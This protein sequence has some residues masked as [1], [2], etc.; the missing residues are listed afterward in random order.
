MIR[1]ELIGT[2][3]VADIWNLRSLSEIVNKSDY[4]YVNSESSSVGGHILHNNGELPDEYEYYDVT[5]SDGMRG[6]AFVS[7]MHSS[8]NQRRC[9]TGVQFLMTLSSRSYI[10]KN[11]QYHLFSHDEKLYFVALFPD[12]TNDLQSV[13]EKKDA[14]VLKL[15]HIIEL[16]EVLSSL[17]LKGVSAGEYFIKSVFFNDR[18]NLVWLGWFLLDLCDERLNKKEAFAINRSVLEI[19]NILE[20]KGIGISWGVEDFATMKA[21]MQLLIERGDP[22]TLLCD[23]RYRVLYNMLEGV[24]VINN[25]P[26]IRWHTGLY[27]SDFLLSLMTTN[28]HFSLNNTKSTANRRASLSAEERRAIDNIIYYLI[29]YDYLGMSNNLSGMEEKFV[30]EFLHKCVDVYADDANGIYYRLFREIA[31][32]ISKRLIALADVFHYP[33]FSKDLINEGFCID[34]GVYSREGVDVRAVIVLNPELSTDFVRSMFFGTEYFGLEVYNIQD[35]VLRSVYGNDVKLTAKSEIIFVGNWEVSGSLAGAMS[36][37]V[38]EADLHLLFSGYTN[39]ELFDI[40][41]SHFKVDHI[42]HLTLFGDLSQI[43]V[44]DSFVRLRRKITYDFCTAFVGE[45]SNKVSFGN[46][47]LTSEISYVSALG[48]VFSAQVNDKN[49][50]VDW[51]VDD[52]NVQ[53]IVITV[54][55]IAYLRVVMKNANSSRAIDWPLSEKHEIIDHDTRSQDVDGVIVMAGGKTVLLDAIPE[56]I[57]EHPVIRNRYI[58]R[59]YLG[60]VFPFGGGMHLHDLKIYTSDDIHHELYERNSLSCEDKFKGIYD[61]LDRYLEEINIYEYLTSGQEM[62]MLQKLLRLVDEQLLQSNDCSKVVRLILFDLR[63]QLT[64]RLMLIRVFNVGD[65]M[66]HIAP[67]MLGVMSSENLKQHLKGIGGIEIEESLSSIFSLLHEYAEKINDIDFLNTSKEL[68][69]LKEIDS[70]LGKYGNNKVKMNEVL[71]SF[72]GGLRN[73]LKVLDIVVV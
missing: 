40:V 21:L 65:D 70:L 55:N 25:I 16:L 54:D 1:S 12:I 73:R 8:R 57:L 31:D 27:T 48:K 51:V 53:D 35:G 61:L 38:A 58:V 52:H 14:D 37:Q 9:L 13:I 34:R 63:D 45:F 11:V 64:S 24:P 26:Y 47:C 23:A 62:V 3:S 10:P 71:S 32:D 28:P 7:A 15:N 30:L 49:M 60:F 59:N 68:V 72:Q 2:R 46:L 22:F 56:E 67:E 4:K 17:R 20:S 39:I 33:W 6:T 5:L 69:L 43:L 41:N 36:S 42:S 66:R 18:G 19:M 44:P 50:L 29:I